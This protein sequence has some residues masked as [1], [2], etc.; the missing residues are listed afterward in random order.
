MKQ[1]LNSI[2]IETRVTDISISGHCENI[3]T[4]IF[5]S[6]QITLYIKM[7][8]Q[9]SRSMDNN[10]AISWKVFREDM[11]VKFPVFLNLQITSK[12]NY[13]LKLFVEKQCNLAILEKVLSMKTYFSESY[14]CI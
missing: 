12:D 5:G 3:S 10:I 13:T 2:L 6:S 14:L 11:K 9:G 1:D 7:V 8:D 4:G